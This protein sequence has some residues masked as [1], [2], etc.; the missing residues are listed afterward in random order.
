MKN[1]GRKREN[2]RTRR[3]GAQEMTRSW[4]QNATIILT[5]ETIIPWDSV[6]KEARGDPLTPIR[7]PL[8]PA[9]NSERGPCLV[10]SDRISRGRSR[11][12]N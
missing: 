1:R 4:V 11:G 10:I 9:R 5:N 6:R 7:S 3:R 12:S 2:G 8:P